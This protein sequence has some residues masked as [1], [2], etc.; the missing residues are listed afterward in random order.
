[1]ALAALACGCAATGGA[2]C[3]SADWYELG[4]RDA[5]LALRPQDPVYA[6]AC[7]KYGV[8]VDSARYA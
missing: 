6:E 2:E 5:L 7:A 3:R 1:M 4:F 8:T